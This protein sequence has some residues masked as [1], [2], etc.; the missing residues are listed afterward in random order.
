MPTAATTPQQD[1]VCERHGGVWMTHAGRLNDEFSVKFQMHRVTWL[2]TAVTWACNS[3]IDD[4]GYSPAQ[5]VL[6]R[7]LRLPY[8]LLDLTGRLSLHERVTRDR[9]CSERI[10]MVSVAQRSITSLRYDRALSRAVLARSRAHGADAARE[11]LQ[12]GDVMHHLEWAA[13]WHAPR[14]SMVCNTFIFSMT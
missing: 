2:T 10:A 12:V 9:T 1:A 14:R 6:A 13:H 8:T 3:A 4:S 7:R 5:W 11:L